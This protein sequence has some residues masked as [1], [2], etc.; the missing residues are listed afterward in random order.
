ME[1]L[2]AETDVDTYLPYPE[3]L[4]LALRF[5]CMILELTDLSMP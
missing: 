5:D 4:T 1:G 2:A 3:D